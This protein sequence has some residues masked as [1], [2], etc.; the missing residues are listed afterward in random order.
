MTPTS[1]IQRPDLGLALE[2]LDLAAAAQGF[3]ATKVFS[4]FDTPLQTANFSRVSLKDLLKK[5]DTTRTPGAGYNRQYSNFEQDNYGTQEHGVEEPVDDREKA[6]YAYT[7]DAEMISTKRAI[8]SILLDLEQRVAAKVF[9]TS[10]WGS[11]TDQAVGTNFN[12]L[13]SSDPTL[14]INKAALAVWELCGIWPNA[15][16]FNKEVYKNVK[17]AASIIDRIKFSGRDDPKNVSQQMLSNLW[18]IE[19]VLVASGQYNSGNENVNSTTATLSRIWSSS[20]AWVGVIARTNDL[21]EPCAGRVFNWTA[22]GSSPNG[23]VEMY[24]DENVRSDI[25]RVRQDTDEKTIHPIA[26]VLLT[27]ITA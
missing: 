6:M 18:D 22:D 16:V 26:G 13:A 24:R 3:I 21:R 4:V 8:F 19:N 10:F 2:E 14:E 20:Y 9:K 5:R 11:A 7:I 25:I 15:V 1:A 17:N 12:N 27:G 23:T